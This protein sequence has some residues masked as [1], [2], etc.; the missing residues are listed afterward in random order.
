MRAWFGTVSRRTS[1][2]EPLRILQVCAPSGVGGL[3]RV[4]QGISEGLVRRGHEVTLAAVLRAGERT[5]PFLGSAAMEGVAVHEIRL[6]GR[7]YLTE[8]R[9]VDRILEEFRP[10]VMHT[11][12]YRPD[13]LHGASARRQRVAAISTLHGSSRMG[14]VSHFFE[15]LQLRALRRFDSVIA[16]SR[17]LA[18]QLEA[19]GVSRERVHLI[20]NAWV[21]PSDPLGRAA[22]RRAL[23]V[24]HATVPVV[25]W[26][27]RLIPIKGCDLLV[28]ALAR[29]QDTEWLAVVVGD[30]PERGL[31]EEW[32]RKVG[33]TERIRFLGSSEDA[34]RLMP[35][36][37]LLV[38][39]SRSEGTPMVLLEAMASGVAPV[40]FGVGGVPDLIESGGGGWIVPPERDDLLAEAISIALRNA[41]ERRERGELA[42]NQVLSTHSEDEWISRH[43]E[44][45]RNA[46][47]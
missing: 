33:L 7:G 12:G 42:R 14:G 40:A 38:L 11:H 29:I 39:S 19:S 30:G 47:G 23:G 2:F 8:L 46:G 1:G 37:D 45:Y 20:P 25:G 31:L 41:R 4:V 18:V 35:G 32:V 5:P 43:E 26:V 44:V 21:P 15:W 36:F 24:E 27:G 9:A 22:A 3:E 28:Q 17:P 13:L 10:R 16:V 6:R 34:S